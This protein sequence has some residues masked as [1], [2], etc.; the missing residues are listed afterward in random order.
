[1][2][3]CNTCCR[4]K[5]RLLWQ[6]HNFLRGIWFSLALNALV[7]LCRLQLEVPLLDK[8]KKSLAHLHW[9]WSSHPFPL[10]NVPAGQSYRRCGTRDGFI[11]HC[12]TAA[13]LFP[14]C[15]DELEWGRRGDGGDW[16][17]LLLLRSD[18]NWAAGR[19]HTRCSMS[20]EATYGTQHTHTVT[21]RDLYHIGLSLPVIYLVLRD[22]H[23]KCQYIFFY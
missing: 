8:R 17:L 14:C 10:Q 1:M 19:V 9:S 20:P 15:A 18:V 12:R 4:F 23:R 2:F 6:H 5:E 16:E 21:Y 22:K 13:E 7:Q 11:F 3:P